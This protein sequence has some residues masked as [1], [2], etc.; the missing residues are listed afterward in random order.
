M[1]AAS[2]S[3]R[4]VRNKF[5]RRFKDF[6]PV[7]KRLLKTRLAVHPAYEFCSLS[8]LPFRIAKI[9]VQTRLPSDF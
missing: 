5:D 9:M 2:T 8:G 3:F 7:E 6:R 1:A 4:Y